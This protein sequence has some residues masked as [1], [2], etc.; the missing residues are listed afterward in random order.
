MVEIINFLSEPVNPKY[1]LGERKGFGE[2]FE[3]K[4]KQLEEKMEE[5]KRK[6]EEQK[7]KR[8]TKKT[9]EREAQQKRQKYKQ[10][11][12]YK[13]YLTITPS[14]ENLIELE[15]QKEKEEEETTRRKQKE[16]EEETKT[17]EED[18]TA[19]IPFNPNK[20]REYPEGF[21]F[22]IKPARKSVEHFLRELPGEA[23][24]HPYKYDIRIY[25]PPQYQNTHH[26]EFKL[27][28]E[29]EDMYI[30]KNARNKNAMKIENVTTKYKNTPKGFTAHRIVF[31]VC[32]FHYQKSHF[33]LHIYL[34]PNNHKKTHENSI[35]IWKTSS[36][37]LFARKTKKDQWPS[38]LSDK[39]E[40]Q[41]EQIH[42]NAL[43]LKK[44]KKATTSKKKKKVV[45]G[46]R[47]DDEDENFQFDDDEF[48]G[49]PTKRKRTRLNQHVHE[50]KAIYSSPPP[51]VEEKRPR[52]VKANYVI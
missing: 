27:Y 28:V 41:Y 35:L 29:R 3:K 19:Q 14:Q 26:V 7:Q 8:I 44:K 49:Q 6:E 39:K 31:Q 4:R 11:R 12:A 38:N 5:A 25:I 32:S 15:R 21:R 17:F 10:M 22:V 51:P 36:F 52:R 48:N 45:S 20:Q 46:D 23:Y 9:S 47:T 24:S 34:V 33:Q 50:A 2:T 18:A 43:K 1:S 16:E 13:K 40:K 37:E 42:K 30:E